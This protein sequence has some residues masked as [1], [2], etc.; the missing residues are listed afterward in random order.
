MGPTACVD[1][2]ERKMSSACGESN[3]GSTCLQPRI[4]AFYRYAVPQE[5]TSRCA[6]GNKLAQNNSTW[7]I[8]VNTNE[9][10]RGSL[11]GEI[12]TANYRR[13]KEWS[14]GVSSG[15]LI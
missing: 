2:L 14:A 3:P 5:N 15:C 12:P 4:A 9:L 6:Q 1:D 11:V 8:F 10:S 13:L 7:R